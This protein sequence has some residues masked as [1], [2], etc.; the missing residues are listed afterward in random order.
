MSFIVLLIIDFKLLFLFQRS[1]FV[2]E[3]AKQLEE[4]AVR[5][6][7]GNLSTNALMDILTKKLTESDTSV[8]SFVRNHLCKMFDSNDLVLFCGQLLQKLH[9]KSAT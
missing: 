9:D 6:I 8:L 4:S 2:E 5:Q 7:S 1:D 3:L